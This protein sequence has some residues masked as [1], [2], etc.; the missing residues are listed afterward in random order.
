M[1]MKKRNKIILYAA[2]CVVSFGVGMIGS[3]VTKRPCV[4]EDA[5]V[6]SDVTEKAEDN[7]EETKEDFPKAEDSETEGSATIESGEAAAENNTQEDTELNTEKLPDEAP[8]A[9][10][11]QNTDTVNVPAENTGE[12]NLININT[13]DAAALM[14]LYGVGEKISQRIIEYRETNG[15]FEVIEDIMKVSGIGEKRFENIKDKICVN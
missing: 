10:T 14:T 11:M 9:E 4:S 2:V 13:A 1:G 3:R 8:A 15:P 6:T 12:T 5:A 7:L